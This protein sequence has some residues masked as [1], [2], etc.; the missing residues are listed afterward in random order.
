[1][2]SS[3]PTPQ[4]MVLRTGEWKLPIDG[5]FRRRASRNCEGVA[6]SVAPY[7]EE[8]ARIFWQGRRKSPSP[9]PTRLTQTHR[10]LAKAGNLAKSTPRIPQAKA[11][12]PVCGSA[13]TTGSEYCAKCVPD[14]NRENLLRQ[15]KLR[16]IAT[17]SAVAEA[18]RSATQAKQAKALRKWNASELPQWLD[19]EFYRRNIL[20]RLAAL[21]VKRLRLAIDGGFCAAAG[22]RVRALRPIAI[23]R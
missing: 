8:A 1:L 19:E 12:C 11:R 20:P 16:Q 22:L 9:L 2:A 14:V 3:R 5:I 23:C 18:R 10:S 13:V 4:G 17:R 21:T 15:A 7:A 6:E